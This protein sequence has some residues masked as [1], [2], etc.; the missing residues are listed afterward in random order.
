[1]FVLASLRDLPDLEKLE[2]AGL[3]S[4]DTLLAEAIPTG[5]GD[6]LPFD[7]SDPTARWVR[8]LRFPR[9]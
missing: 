7:D 5:G 2:D 3:L 1:M 4:N 9:G 8:P 6:D